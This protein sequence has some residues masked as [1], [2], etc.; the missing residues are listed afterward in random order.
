LGG[1]RALQSELQATIAFRA[2][3]SE[4]VFE[5]GESM[6][7]K[8][9]AN[10]I[11]KKYFGQQ[12]DPDHL[13]LVDKFLGGMQEFASLFDQE[14]LPSKTTKTATVTLAAD[15][16]SYCLVLKPTLHCL[17]GEDNRPPSLT[18]CGLHQ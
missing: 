17:L 12:D 16:P 13:S 3:D 8:D 2:Y 1:G 14:E 6:K 5:G 9:V 4:Q 15:Q 11:A 7:K 18:R 10:I